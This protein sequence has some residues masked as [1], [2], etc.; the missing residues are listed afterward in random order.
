[1]TKVMDVTSRLGYLMLA[2]V[3]CSHPEAVASSFLLGLWWMARSAC[4]STASAMGAGDCGA[5]QDLRS[6]LTLDLGGHSLGHV[7]RTWYTELTQLK[8]LYLDHYSIAFQNLTGLLTLHP[9]GNYLV[10]FT[11]AALFLS[12]THGTVTVA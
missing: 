11:W 12:S 3:E 4:W 8:L 10:V 7:A 6:L 1:M 2:Q 9:I 5:V